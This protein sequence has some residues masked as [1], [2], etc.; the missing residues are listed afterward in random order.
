MWIT[1]RAVTAGEMITLTFRRVLERSMSDDFL[2]EMNVD[3]VIPTAT[4]AMSARRIIRLL[5][6]S[7]ESG[8]LTGFP[9]KS[10]LQANS[11]DLSSFVKMS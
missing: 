1:S 3:P 7:L 11:H 5:E 2:L 8:Y 6:V 4:A 9:L 10:S